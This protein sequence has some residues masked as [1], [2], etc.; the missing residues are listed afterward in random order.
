MVPPPEPYSRHIPKCRA[1][2]LRKILDVP[3]PEPSSWHIPKCRAVHLSKILDV[4]LVLSELQLFHAACSAPY[5]ANE[6]SKTYHGKRSSFIHNMCHW[7]VSLRTIH[8][9]EDMPHC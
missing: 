2:H 4:P 6:Q 3:P 8:S 1:V 5:H 7:M 9:S